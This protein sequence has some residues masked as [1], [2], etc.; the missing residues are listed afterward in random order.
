MNWDKQDFTEELRLTKET[1]QNKI[2]N[3]FTYT[4]DYIITIDAKF[5]KRNRV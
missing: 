3:V 2:I 4:I 5:F 1:Q